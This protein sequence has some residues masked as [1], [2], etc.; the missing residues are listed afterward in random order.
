MRNLFYIGVTVGL[1]F[2]SAAAWA[3]RVPT[4]VESAMLVEMDENGQPVSNLIQSS[5]LASPR[6]IT[7]NETFGTKCPPGAVCILAKIS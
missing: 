5:L 4:K 3:K 2:F 7:L 6:K 1:F